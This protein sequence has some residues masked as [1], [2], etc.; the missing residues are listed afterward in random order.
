MS[1]SAYDVVGL[2]SKSEQRSLRGQREEHWMLKLRKAVVICAVAAISLALTGTASAF[3]APSIELTRGTAEPVESITTQLGAVV[4][5]GGNDAFRLHVK[6][7]GGEGCGANAGADH[8]D[9]VLN[10]GVTAE[11]NPVHF[12]HNWTFQMAGTYKLC[13]WVSTGSEEVLAFAETTFAVRAP[14]LALSITV[15]ATV[16]PQQTFQVSTTA[17]AE[18]ERPVW[19]YVMPNTG[20]GCPANAAAAGRASGSNTILDVWNVTGGPFTETKNES[21]SSPGVYLDCAYFEY[22]SAESPPEASASAVTSVV[23][24]PP[25]CV[26]P[27]FHRGAA[28]ASVE[29]AVRAASCSV[30]AVHYTASSSVGRGGVLALSPGTGTTLG[31]GAAVSI[32]VSA[33]RPCVV[34]AVK[35]GYTVG[36]VKHLLAAADCGA[37]ITHAH[38][39]H[40]RRGRVV[41]LGSRA[42][43]RLFPLSK[44]RIVVSVGR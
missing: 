32:T 31:T 1:A 21:L 38:S 39:R 27:A 26:V 8:G 28:L 30:G 16:Q 2:T 14:H 25:P 22:P 35:P 5:N 33:G 19:E 4:S 7:T 41:G 44:V 18:T 20:D 36:H 11:T 43:S 15:P 9:E 17:Q 3:A 23:P 24:P 12:S 40:V 6:P 42:H 10:E 13:A 29:Q 37:V 34:P